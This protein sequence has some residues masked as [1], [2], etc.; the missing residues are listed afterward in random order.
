MEVEG[1]EVSSRYKDDSMTGADEQSGDI[2]AAFEK[3]EGHNGVRGELPFVEE[4]DA[5]CENAEDQ[6]TDDGGRFP[7]VAD[8]A[9]FEAQEEH[10]SSTNDKYGS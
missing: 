7:R 9:V 3:T 10:D 5:D 6:E 4:E 1:E 8:A 2:G